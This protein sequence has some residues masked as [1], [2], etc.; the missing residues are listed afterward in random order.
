MKMALGDLNLT[1]I[2]AIVMHAPGTVKGDVSE[3]KAIQKV[4]GETLPFLT[5]NNWS[6]TWCFRNVKCRIGYLYVATSAGNFCSVYERTK[7]TQTTKK[8]PCKCGWFWRKCRFCFDT[9]IR[10]LS[11]YNSYFCQRKRR[12]SRNIQQTYDGVAI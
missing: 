3:Y 7:T 5:T 4:F 8:S 6:Y 9:K 1:A 12:N 11:I 10:E 2:D